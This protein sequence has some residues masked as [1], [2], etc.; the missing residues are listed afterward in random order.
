MYISSTFA[1]EKKINQFKAQA[2]LQIYLKIHSL[3]RPPWNSDF[4]PLTTPFQDCKVKIM[5]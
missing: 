3:N 5:S 4:V 2:K 1:K